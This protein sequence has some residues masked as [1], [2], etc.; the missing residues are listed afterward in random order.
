MRFKSFLPITLITCLILIVSTPFQIRAGNAPVN[1]DRILEKNQSNFQKKIKNFSAK[2]QKKFDR[3]MKRINNKLNKR[4]A[5]ED[6]RDG[7][8]TGLVIV[9][10]GAALALLG[11]TGIADILVSI[12][13]VVLVLG[14]LFW[15]LGL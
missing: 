7:V 14:L 12:G 11:L 1:H 9:V 10:I 8:R 6:V 3:K 15:L 5:S 2:Q 4:H 13:L